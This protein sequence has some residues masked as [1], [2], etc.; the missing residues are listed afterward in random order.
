MTVTEEKMKILKMLEDGKINAEQANE[1]L[2]ALT[3]IDNAANPSGSDSGQ[4]ADPKPAK[5]FVVRV[6][7]TR[8]G[9]RK[10]NVRLPV[11]VLRVVQRFGDVKSMFSLNDAGLEAMSELLNAGKTGMVA[12]V[13][14]EKDNEHVEVFFE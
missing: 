11:G 14:E 3:S 6:T 1:L 9:K 13:M 7:D 8:T 2:S 5:W 10:A 4:T 12:D